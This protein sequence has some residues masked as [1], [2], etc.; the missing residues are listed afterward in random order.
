MAVFKL[1]LALLVTI[2]Y[3]VS[4]VIRK[5]E[6]LLSTDKWHRIFTSR[7]PFQPKHLLQSGK[8]MQ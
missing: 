4:L 5:V 3:V 7:M 1:K 6:N 8:I 2:L